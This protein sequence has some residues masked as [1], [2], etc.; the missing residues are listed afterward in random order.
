[1][2]SAAPYSMVPY[3]SMSQFLTADIAAWYARSTVFIDEYEEI[4]YF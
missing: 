1:M 4:Y 2:Y 3:T